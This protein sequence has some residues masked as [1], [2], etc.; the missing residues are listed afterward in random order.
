MSA[1]AP[2]PP[3]PDL[4]WRAHDGGLLVDVRLTPRAGH[5]RIDGLKL[6]ADGRPVLVARVRAVPEKG[7][8]NEALVRLIAKALRLG[9]TDVSVTSGH[10]SR[11]KTLHI[12]GDPG[13][14]AADLKRLV[15]PPA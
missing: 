11:T 15:D 13:Y 14:L 2:S 3:S 5:D 10:T 9:R 12:A 8:A 7:A 6:L 4:P 1:A